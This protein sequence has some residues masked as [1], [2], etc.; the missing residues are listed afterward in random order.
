MSRLT[1]AAI[2]ASYTAQNVVLQHLYVHDNGDNQQPG[3]S[4]NE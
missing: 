4:C 1:T 3:N 2:G